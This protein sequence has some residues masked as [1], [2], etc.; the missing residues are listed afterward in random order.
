MLSLSIF[1]FFPSLSFSVLVTAWAFEQGEQ[2]KRQFS[3]QDVVVPWVLPAEHDPLR[4]EEVK[5]GKK[6][7]PVSVDRYC[8]VFKK[9]ELEEQFALIP[10]V[11]V[12]DSYFDQDNWAVIVKKIAL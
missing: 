8:H 7:D 3:T 2:S 10:N 5:G 12:V 6:L 9:G 11:Q 4:A 1:S